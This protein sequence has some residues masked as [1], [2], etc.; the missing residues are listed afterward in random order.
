[1]LKNYIKEFF[2]YKPPDDRI[3]SLEMFSKVSHFLEEIEINWE[4]GTLH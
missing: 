3:M 2:F 4:N 1:V